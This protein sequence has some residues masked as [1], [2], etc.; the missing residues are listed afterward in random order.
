MTES[1][2]ELPGGVADEPRDCHI[3]SLLGHAVHALAA[4][5][6]TARLDAEVLL[7][8]CVDLPRSTLL[9]FPERSVSAEAR[10]R[11]T[12]AVERR[13]RG[14]P[15]AYIRGAKE[16]YSLPFAVTPGVLI[17]RADTEILVDAALAYLDERE[18]CSVL[19]VGTGSGAIAIAIKHERPF[20]AVTALDYDGR[21][22]AV[23]RD[24]AVRLG[25]EIRCVR[26]NWLDA[27]PGERF[28][29]IVS[30]PPYIL[31]TDRELE[32]A[33]R[34][35]PRLALDGGDDGLAA[36]RALM[37]VVPAHFAPGGLL[38]VEH[39]HDQRPAVV[40]LAAENGLVLRAAHDDLAGI[41]RVAVFGAE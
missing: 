37:R 40:A 28:D 11:F 24:N 6:P 2:A 18:R 7:A 1:P 10:R 27:L 33:L 35:E 25:V 38:L 3:G 34:F 16:F 9:A 36:Y 8:F 21:A 17:P 12:A 31:S 13:A 19:D 41:P 5:S 39:G 15:I 14:E 22:L 23:A 20:A 30:N 26:S 4:H 29:V 32:G